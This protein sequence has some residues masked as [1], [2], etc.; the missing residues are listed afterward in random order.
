[1]LYQ[2]E[3][4][5]KQ[6]EEVRVLIERT[7]AIVHDV[8][9]AG[10][11]I[12]ATLY[13]TYPGDEEEVQSIIANIREQFRWLKSAYADDPE[14]LELVSDID[15]KI[16][17]GIKMIRDARVELAT[18]PNSAQRQKQARK[19]NDRFGPTM[20]LV[21]PALSGLI[22]SQKGIEKRLPAKQKEQ[23]ETLKG[24]VALAFIL[25]IIVVLLA[26]VVF[27][28][29]IVSKIKKVLDN[30]ERL[31]AGMKL[32]PALE[33]ADE[34]GE[35]DRVF[36]KMADELNEAT[37]KERAVVDYATDVISSVDARGKFQAVSPAAEKCWRYTP[38]QLLGTS[39]LQIITLDDVD[40]TREAMQRIR[41]TKT[42]S[43]FENRVTTSDG[44]LIPT[45]WSAHWSDSE[46]AMFCVAHDITDR[47]RA[48]NLLKES[49]E[50]IRTIIE[51]M[52]L[53]LLLLNVDGEVDFANAKA[54]EMFKF[55]E[56]GLIGQS[57]TSLFS[58]KDVE[59]QSFQEQLMLKDSGRTAELTGIKSNQQE[60]PVEFTLNEYDSTQGLRFLSV[61]VDVTERHEIQKMRQAFVSLVSHELRTPLSSVLG[62]L[63][64]VEM[65]VFGELPEELTKGSLRAERNVERLVGLINDLL[66]LEKLES[67][68][69]SVLMEPV[70]TRV[71]CNNAFES[72]NEFAK[73][74]Q[75]TLV[76]D[77]IEADV[78]ADEGRI[79]QVLVNLLSNAIKFSPANSTVVLEVKS[80]NSR[81]AEI[82]VIDQGRGVPLQ[83]QEVIFERF[84]QVQQS[85]GKRGAGTGLGLAICKT[86]VEQHGG[87]IAVQSEPE[88]GSRF[89]F[90][91]PF[92]N[93]V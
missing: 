93:A 76:V 38:S 10:E 31:Q 49:E 75:V 59:A 18:V 9:D 11:R 85:D 66:D 1:M 53:G 17:T 68:T 23:R 87:T 26:S 25:N 56:G 37:R 58:L 83:Y 89:W 40:M 22:A 52:P 61:I 55:D 81:L 14:N 8:Y 7:G 45:L 28:R 44:Q 30:T 16:E 62:H 46:E 79:N 36:H 15:S 29:N 90:T 84:Q 32:S 5:A 86:I 13:H 54:Y 19:I 88:K 27:S 63:Q 39:M 67:G 35:L 92:A 71:L 3:K 47:K 73:K 34:I 6:E 70:E 69:L 20:T 12:T 64:L 57:V 24:I 43:Y 50:R 82:S 2:S 80:Y 41:S 4:Q 91:L 72:V 33:S 74:H 65:G 42:D 60:F 78:M 77:C 48:E 51:K 21:A